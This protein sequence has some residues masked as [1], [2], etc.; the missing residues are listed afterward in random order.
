VH[1]NRRV[2]P[3]RTTAVRVAAAGIVAAL[4]L[5]GCSSSSDPEPE[6]A[7]TAS[8]P[9]GFKVP[10][11]VT[12]TPGGTTLTVGKPATVVHQVGDG[13]A[14][15]VTVAVTGIEPG[16]IDDFRFFS[17][18]DVTKKSAPYY[19]TV[20]VTNVGPA[21][22]GG[23]ALPIFVRDSANTN[24]PANDIVGT[25]KPCP[26]ATLPQTFLPA[27]TASLCLVY[28]VPEGRTLESIVLQTGT[29]DDAVSWKP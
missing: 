15:A 24:L 22:L 12:L 6:P 28:L 25:F 7:P 29:A 16:S 11:G 19:V 3:S 17:L 14:S 26:T 20:T 13:A 1:D 27:A 2:R 18:D 8:V 9:A 4:A 5:G 23:A 10:A 21:G